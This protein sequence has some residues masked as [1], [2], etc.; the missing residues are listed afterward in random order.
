M[1]FLTSYSNV[2]NSGRS[3]TDL[4]YEK[5]NDNNCHTANGDEMYSLLFY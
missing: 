3:S 1:Q 5:I 2:K 4:E